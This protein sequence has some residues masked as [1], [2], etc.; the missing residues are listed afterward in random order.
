MNQFMHYLIGMMLAST[1]YSFCRPVLMK[2]KSFV[3]Y[4]ASKKIVV[5]LATV[6]WFVITGGIFYLY[7][8]S[9]FYTTT[10]P[11]LFVAGVMLVISCVFSD[12]RLRFLLIML[13]VLILGIIRYCAY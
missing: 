11:E 8:P 2:N 10:V 12:M 9:I 5:T 7:E 1:M 3:R 13:T 4:Y 6:L